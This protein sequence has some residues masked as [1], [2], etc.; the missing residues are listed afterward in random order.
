SGSG[1]N[2]RLVT[3]MVPLDY[4]LK[5]GEIVDIVTSRTAHPTRDWLNFARTAAAKSKIR[6][7]LKTHERD[8]NIQIG[9][10]R[11]D[12]ELKVMGVRGVDMLTED[13]QNW[14]SHEYHKES[15]EDVLAAIGWDDI[16]QHGVAVKLIDFWQQREQRDGK[17]AKEEEEPLTLPGISKQMPSAHLQ[18]AGVSGLLTSLANCCCP[19]PGDEI[20]GFIS[21][22]KGAIIHRADCKNIDRYRERE[23]ERLVNV[24]WTTMGYQHYLAPV[25][26]TARDRSGLIRDIATVVSEIGVN[27]AS[28][29]SSVGI[30]K[31]TAVINATLEIDGLEQL[32]RV[33]T[34]LEKVKGVMHVERDLGKSKKR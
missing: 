22:G 16:R 9:R 3:R 10:E 5:S 26:I 21:R 28:V 15:F 7:Y 17:E 33:F 20:V 19:L 1:D 24:S 11:L 2:E 12:R 6:R 32:Q 4:E 30:G 29:S 34:R 27:M 8:I 31:E 25:L 13:A 23:R 18:V 14:L